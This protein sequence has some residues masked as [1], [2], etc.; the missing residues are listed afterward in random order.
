MNTALWSDVEYIDRPETE[1]NPRVF[2]NIVNNDDIL[3]MY[4]KEMVKK[5]GK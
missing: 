3:Q 2:N 5:G 4:L 1:D